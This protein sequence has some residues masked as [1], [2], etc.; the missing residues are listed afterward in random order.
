M[1]HRPHW[2]NCMLTYFWDEAIWRIRL[3]RVCLSCASIQTVKKVPSKFASFSIVNNSSCIHRE[4]K[5]ISSA[6]VGS[7]KLYLCPE[8][9]KTKGQISITQHLMPPS[10]LRWDCGLLK[11]TIQLAWDLCSG[12]V[13]YSPSSSLHSLLLVKPISGLK[14]QYLDL[15]RSML[16]L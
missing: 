9:L 11:A 13:G 12:S 4:G 16:S 1:V 14:S 2:N 7:W 10:W 15:L 3:P 8:C 6:S 5:W